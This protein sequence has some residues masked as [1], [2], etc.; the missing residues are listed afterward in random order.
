MA[1]LRPILAR[2]PDVTL[3]WVDA[4]ALGHGYTDFAICEFSDLEQ[5]HFLWEELRDTE[6][7]T[8]PLVAMKDVLLGL[9]DGFRRFEES[10]AAVGT[11]SPV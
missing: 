4:D 7:F 10:G 1:R 3:R 5:Y 6:L 11:G 8:R 2:H 9:E